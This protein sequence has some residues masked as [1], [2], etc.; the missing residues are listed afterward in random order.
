MSSR[1]LQQHLSACVA[2]VRS[3]LSHLESVADDFNDLGR[4]F[5]HMARFEEQLAQ[6]QGQYTV[7][8]SSSTQRAADLQHLGY[9][10]LRQHTVEKQVGMQL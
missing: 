8:G 5:C 2:A 1:E 3:L 10:A 6:R 9:A 7:S 4:S